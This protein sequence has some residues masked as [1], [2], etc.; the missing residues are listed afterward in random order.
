MAGRI[1][2]VTAPDLGVTTYTYDDAGNVLTRRDDNNHVTSWVYDD[3]GRLA[4]ETKPDPDGG[5]S[6]TSPLTTYT[7][8]PNGNQ[9]T[10]TDPNGNATGTAGDGVTTFGYDRANRQTSIDYADSTR[11]SPS[12]T[13]MWAIERR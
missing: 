10:L 4:S 11:T 5:G 6:Q 1:L 2:S 7:Y 12:P 3:A 8:D 9:L 13:T